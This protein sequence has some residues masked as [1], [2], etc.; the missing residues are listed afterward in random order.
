MVFTVAFGIFIEQSGIVLTV[1]TKKVARGGPGSPA[2]RALAQDPADVFV[3]LHSI[4]GI[5][6]VTDFFLSSFSSPSLLPILFGFKDRDS[7]SF[8][9]T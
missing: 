7:L 6:Q 2:D 8:Y 9:S 5:G 4:C 3:T 1:T